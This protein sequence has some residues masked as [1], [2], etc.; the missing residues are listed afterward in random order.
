VEM[1]KVSHQYNNTHQSN[2]H[3]GSL[4]QHLN[5]TDQDHM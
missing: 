2:F 1:M 5:S 3:L 4:M